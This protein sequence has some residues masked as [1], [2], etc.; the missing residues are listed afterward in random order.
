MT[1]NPKL[2]K[3]HILGAL[4]SL[5]RVELEAVHAMAG[6][7]L[8]ATAANGPGA[9]PIGRIV[10][11]ALAAALGLTM[12]YSSYSPTATRQF[13]KRLPQLLAFFS[14][15][16]KSWDSNK[17]LQTA[18]LRMM[19]ELLVDDLKERNV[20]PTVGILVTNMP[21]LREV[22]DNAFPNYLACGM[23]PMIIKNLAKGEP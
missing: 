21:R 16:F 10:F 17:V 19:F 5:E 9:N 23:G 1:A 14:D 20:T 3:E 18:F 2:T 13:E 4:P 22:F 6:H 11:E 8:G 12:P 15:E 7:L